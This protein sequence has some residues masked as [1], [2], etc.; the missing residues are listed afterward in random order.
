MRARSR[1]P[2]GW[3]RSPGS[4][5]SIALSSTSSRSSCR[6]RRGPRCMRWSRRACLAGVARAA[7]SGAGGACQRAGRRRHR[8]RQRRGYQRA[9]SRAQGGVPMTINQSGWKPA[10]PVAAAGDGSTTTGNRALMLEEALIFEIGDSDST[11]VDIIAARGTARRA[12]T[13]SRAMARSAC[14]ACPNRRRC[15]T[16]RACHARIMPSTLACSPWD[17]AR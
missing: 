8:S 1:L 6:S 10:A 15:V 3:A 4:K 17:H 5:S 13:A 9:R 16:T 2:I 14:R 11:G 7:L 12:S